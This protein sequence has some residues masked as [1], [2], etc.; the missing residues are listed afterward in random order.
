[1][2]SIALIIIIALA[3]AFEFTNGFQDTA[4]AIATSIYTRAMSPRNAIMLAAVMN[5]VGALAGEKV[6]MTI[7]KGLIAV[8]LPEYVIASALIAATV[9]NIVA[10]WRAIPISCSHALIGGLLGSSIAYTS[11]ADSVIWAGV[12]KKV[13]IP[14]VTS[15]IFGFLI[16]F[17]IMTVIFKLLYRLSYGRVNMIFL[18]LQLLSAAMVA[19]SHGN[20]DAQKTMGVITMA[21]ISSGFLP[22]AAGVPAWVKFICALTMALGTAAGGRKVIKT[23]GGRVT[24]LEP[25][26][27]FSAQTAAA[28][29]IEGASFIGAPV[30]TT[31]VITSTIMGAGA[32]KRVSAVKWGVA[33]NIV[34]AWIITLPSTMIIGGA[35]SLALGNFFQA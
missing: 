25:T 20:N 31:Q 10:T 4:N 7:S 15:P 3:L 18:R 26:S 12:A 11:S 2:L 6:A 22:A 19:F 33:Q 34:A 35:I 23:M 16:G 9:W 17:L 27:G 21:L 5:F 30:S 28:I 24:R 1:M 14:L 8:T 32:A 13:L 29:V